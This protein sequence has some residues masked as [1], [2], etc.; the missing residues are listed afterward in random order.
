MSWNP[1][2]DTLGTKNALCDIFEVTASLTTLILKV[3]SETIMVLLPTNSAHIR[4]IP[5]GIGPSPTK[6]RISISMLSKYRQNHRKS[7]RW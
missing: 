7:L 4:P 1:A 6:R 5:D 3:L 2:K